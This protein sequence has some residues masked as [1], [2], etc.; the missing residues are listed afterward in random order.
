MDPPPERIIMNIQDIADKLD[1]LAELR[2]APGI[3]QAQKQEIIN[4]VLTPAIRVQLEEIDIEFAHSL[5]VAAS[6]AA[7]LETDIKNDILTLGETVHGSALMATWNKGRD[8]EWD[9]KKLK[10]YA[11]NHPEINRLQKPNGPP[12]VSIRAI[13]G[14]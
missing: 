4:Q 9:S 7:Q 2:S 11:I 5:Q 6:A 10:E 13:K 12:T 8:G 3:I 14:E 1:L